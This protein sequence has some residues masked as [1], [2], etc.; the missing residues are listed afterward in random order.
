MRVSIM[1][2]EEIIKDIVRSEL[3]ELQTLPPAEPELI[4][5]NEA[6][7][8]CGCNR[9]VIDELVHGSPA[10]G[11]PAVRLG[12]KTIRIDKRRLST[13]FRTGG[14]EVRA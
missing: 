1:I 10:N 6:C 8:L 7:T 13:W 2:I 14:L 5:I 11:F 3:A 4:T 12:S 9:T